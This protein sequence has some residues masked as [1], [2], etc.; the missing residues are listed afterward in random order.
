[1]GII[2]LRDKYSDH[3]VDSDSL[4]FDVNDVIGI[5]C[6]ENYIKSLDNKAYKLQR[7]DASDNLDSIYKGH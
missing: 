4:N 2:A 5:T 1:M 3:D 7:R 6:N